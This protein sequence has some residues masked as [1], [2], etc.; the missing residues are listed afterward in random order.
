MRSRNGAARPTLPSAIGSASD[1]PG[2]LGR[3][4]PFLRHF[5]GR[6]VLA[7]VECLSH[8]TGRHLDDAVQ[9]AAAA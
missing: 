9:V 6:L 8:E 7:F 1:S 4:E 2:L 5:D 3:A